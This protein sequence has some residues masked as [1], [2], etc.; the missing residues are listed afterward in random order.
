MNVTAQDFRDLTET[1]IKNS[2]NARIT[3]L[4]KTVGEL[5]ELVESVCN[6]L[7]AHK[8]VD[9]S[10]WRQYG[11]ITDVDEDTPD[12]YNRMTNPNYGGSK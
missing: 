1:R 7:E 3:A 6:L 8:M 2:L 5:E 10:V 12:E 4:E 11:L 9:F